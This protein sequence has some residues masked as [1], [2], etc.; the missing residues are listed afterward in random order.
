M[1]Y[2]IPEL[3]HYN[4][5]EGFGLSKKV[6]WK[7]KESKTIISSGVVDEVALLLEQHNMNVALFQEI[8]API[9]WIF[10]AIG[11]N[12]QSIWKFLY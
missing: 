12:N 5:K 2:A 3:T 9:P 6:L 1:K 10:F 8:P 4:S 7:S 11:L